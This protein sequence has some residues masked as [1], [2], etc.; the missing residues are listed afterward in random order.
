MKHRAEGAWPR[1]QDRHGAGEG[2]IERIILISIV[3]NHCSERKE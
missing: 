3:S 2:R 1:A